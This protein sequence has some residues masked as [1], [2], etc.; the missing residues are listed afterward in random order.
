MRSRETEFKKKDSEKHI[1]F[2]CTY[3][4]EDKMYFCCPTILYYNIIQYC[5]T[6]E[7]CFGVCLFC[8]FTKIKRVEKQHMLI[9]CTTHRPYYCAHDILHNP[10]S[11]RFEHYH[12]YYI[13]YFDL[14]A[15]G[16]NEF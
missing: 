16:R 4:F 10:Y 3:N 11:I 12:C 9:Y 15:I 6:R 5:P 7:I 8:S 14:I 1:E 13:Y 2:C